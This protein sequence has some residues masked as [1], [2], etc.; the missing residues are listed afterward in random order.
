MF[1]V[2]LTHKPLAFSLMD[3]EY[4]NI[5]NISATVVNDAGNKPEHVIEAKVSIE[6]TG[7]DEPTKYDKRREF[8]GGVV[9]WSV[10]ASIVSII[11]CCAAPFM[12]TL[13]ICGSVALIISATIFFISI[14]QAASI[15]PREPMGPT[16]WYYGAL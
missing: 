1:F 9:A 2:S 10:I 5:I 16:P 12:G 14:F 15:D 6:V 3:K 4:K 7:E 8:W 13:F 11:V